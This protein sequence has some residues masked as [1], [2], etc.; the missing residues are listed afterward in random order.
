MKQGT[1]YAFAA[2]FSAAALLL[3]GCDT[4]NS[5]SNVTLAVT[6][7]SL[8]YIK[9]ANVF[10]EGSQ[11]AAYA[12]GGTYHFY[13]G[14]VTGKRIAA[15]GSYV[16]N[17][18]DESNTSVAPTRCPQFET[19]TT[20]PVLSAPGYTEG[21]PYEAIYININPFTSLIAEGNMTADEMMIEYEA[22]YQ[23]QLDWEKDVINFD[24]DVTE[25][26]RYAEYNAAEYNLTEEICDALDRLN[27]I[28]GLYP[29]DNVTDTN[30]SDVNA[31]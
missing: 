5:D 19:N 30:T 10:L 27:R 12:S 24:F 11:N 25:A 23:V 17:E 29:D 14:D 26:L 9:D 28:Q 21:T 3:G 2:A 18:E 13:E 16:T 8:H 20:M 15:G 1:A 31:S 6:V 22:A 4:D 7:S